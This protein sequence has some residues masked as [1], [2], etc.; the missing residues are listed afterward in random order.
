MKL[1]DYDCIRRMLGDCPNCA[2]NYNP[3]DPLS[4]LYC[5]RYYPTTR[6]WA[7]AV[8]V[9]DNDVKRNVIDRMKELYRRET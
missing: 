8:V 6:T 1:E 7:S 9:F 3:D 5:P 2:V 4:N